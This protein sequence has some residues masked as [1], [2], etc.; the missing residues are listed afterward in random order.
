VNTPHFPRQLLVVAAQLR[1]HILRIDVVGI[2]VENALLAGDVADRP[3]RRA[4]N[5]ARALGDVVGHGE[6]LVRLLVQQ[7]VI[8]AKMRA[9]HV[10]VEI[11]GFQVQRE[12]IRQQRVQRTRDI[13]RRIGAQAVARIKRGL[14]QLFGRFGVF[15][16][17]E[18]RV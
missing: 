18:L 15:H 5:L 3:Q 11:L 17:H 6:D 14:A 13:A 4:A 9:R 12:G 16:R 2:V 8:I 10:P 7:Q 1:Q